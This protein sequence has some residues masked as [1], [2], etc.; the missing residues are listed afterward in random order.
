VSTK[1]TSDLLDEFDAVDATGGAEIEPDYNVAPTV[2]VRMVVNRPLRPSAAGGGTTAERPDLDSA[3]AGRPADRGPAVRQLRRARWGLVPSWAKDR[4]IGNT[5]INA[6]AESVLTKAAFRRA[7]AS[8][9]CLI[10]ADGWYEWQRATDAAGKPH[11]QPYL[12]TPPDG[13]SLAFA[14]LYEFWRP[15]DAPEGTDLLVSAAIITVAAVG[16]LAEIHDRMPLVLHVDTWADWLDPA[17]AAPTELLVPRDE[18]SIESLEL[19]PVSSRV[20]TVQNNSPDLLD[21][22]EPAAAAQPLF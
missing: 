3:P 19:R 9:R 14:G 1:S 16:E 8:R 10:P 6:R 17:N 2:E 18:A 22:V 11:K 4:S 13:H 7:F 15:A 21:R 12:M 20:N 5:M